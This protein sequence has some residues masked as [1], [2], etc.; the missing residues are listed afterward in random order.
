LTKDALTL[1]RRKL[2][3][4]LDFDTREKAQNMINK[5]EDSIDIFK[6]GLE[7]YL[8]SRG[9]IVEYL[10][11]K[12]KKVFL[13][14]KF[15]DIPNTVAGAAREATKMGVFM[16]NVHTP[17]GRVMMEA[18][19]NAVEQVVTA[20]QQ[21]PLLI[22][23]TVLTSLDQNDLKQLGI[24]QE[25]KELVIARAKLAKEAGLDGVVAS[26]KE[27]GEIKKVC[28]DDF[29]SVCPGVRP[30]WASM[31]DQKRVM[32]P[33]D[34][35]NQGASYLVVGRPITGGQDPAQNAIKVLEEMEEG[36]KC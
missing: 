1:A 17:G 16:F 11:N 33:K 35:I 5:L 30:T 22:G 18:A 31:G 36:F 25:V 14:L 21:K 24:T 32:T 7:L 27:A 13:D 20:G 2:I 6:V 10:H 3:V 29:I 12:G 23:V 4:A 28:G 15:M 9:K 8:A 19:R 26:P 34:A